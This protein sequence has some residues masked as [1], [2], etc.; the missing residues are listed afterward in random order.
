MTTVAVTNSKYNETQH[1]VRKYASFCFTSLYA[2][3]HGC[4][5][6]IQGV[7]TQTREFPAVARGACI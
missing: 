7:Q 6:T 1:H 2:Q 3:F 4:A 5:L